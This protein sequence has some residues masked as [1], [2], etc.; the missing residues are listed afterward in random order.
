MK[1]KTLS[2]VVTSKKAVIFDL[3]HTLTAIET[4]WGNGLPPT[5][6]MLGVSKEAWSFQLF[7]NSRERL[8]GKT[9]DPSKIVSE[10]AWAIDPSISPEKIEAAVE[11]RK[12]RFSAALTDIPD[13][14]INVLKR[15]KAMKK[16]IGLISNADVMEVAAWSQS[17]LMPLFDSTVL[18][19]FAGCAK[20]EKE[21]YQISL[22]Q[23]KVAP[24]ESIFVGDG[25]SNELEGAKNLG[26]TAVMI[27]GI[28]RKIYPETIEERMRQADFVIE[29]LCE[30]FQK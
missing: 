14:T 8:T 22:Q 25:G 3:F 30:L 4:T 26:I 19:C 5:H 12:K 17:P 20:P 15:L 21:I 24:E 13:E 9:T 28:V 11:N 18:S 23:M 16:K 2:A 29:Y 1:A 6:E 10:I 7:Q 27:A